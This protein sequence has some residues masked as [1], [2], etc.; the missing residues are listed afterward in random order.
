MQG[1]VLWISLDLSVGLL[2]K[3]VRMF[4]KLGQVVH[5]VKVATGRCAHVLD[6]WWR[7]ERCCLLCVYLDA[8]KQCQCPVCLELVCFPKLSVVTL[9]HPLGTLPSCCCCAAAV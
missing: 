8:V 4:C 2:C 5:P 6:Y 3:V 7:Q 1:Y 9:A